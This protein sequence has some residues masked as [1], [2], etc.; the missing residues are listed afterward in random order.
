MKK[1]KIFI[2]I[3]IPMNMIY[4]DDYEYYVS[5]KPSFETAYSMNFGDYDKKVEYALSFNL[6]SEF[7]TE[8]EDKVD[9]P[10]YIDYSYFNGT[11]W[12]YVDTTISIS[13]NTKRNYDYNFT[14]AKNKNYFIINKESQIFNKNKYFFDLSSV[15]LNSISTNLNLILSSLSSH[16]V[17]IDLELLQ[18][19]KVIIIF[20]ITSYN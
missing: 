20:P 19:Y 14:L 10:Y 8:D 11:E 3:I 17:L 6:S 9:I 13:R 2:M 1:L 16:K 5:I 7:D 15:C 12:I 18:W 4:S